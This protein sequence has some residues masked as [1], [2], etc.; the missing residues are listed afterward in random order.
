MATKS[1][2]RR[3]I[4]DIDRQIRELN[5]ARE[6]LIRTRTTTEDSAKGTKRTRRS[7][8]AAATVQANDTGE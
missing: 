1:V 6:I 3:A 5:T 8:V 4:D 2:F 7:R